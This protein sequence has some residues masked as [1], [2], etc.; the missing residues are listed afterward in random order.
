MGIY[1]DISRI[2]PGLEDIHISSGYGFHVLGY[3]HLCRYCT[4]AP[5]IFNLANIMHA[6]RYVTEQADDGQP[7]VLV[8]LT[9]PM[10]APG[11]PSP[12]QKF[13][14]HDVC[15]A[16]SSQAARLPPDQ[17]EDY[18]HFCR[19]VVFPGSDT[20]DVAGPPPLTP[21]SSSFSS[22]SCSHPPAPPT[23]SSPAPAPAP[24]T[25]PPPPRAL[26]LH[27]HLCCDA[28]LVL[29]LL[30][31]NLPPANSPPHSPTLILLCCCCC[32][33]SP[34]PAPALSPLPPLQPSCLLLLRR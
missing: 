30:P 29:L 7:L 28:V 17:I 10:Q 31:L 1:R 22:C 19:T 20:P 33:P 13:P 3:Q 24:H 12:S 14:V 23:A 5:L 6:Y 16:S 15:I 32:R 4:V 2:I 18:L 26:V 11:H 21:P 27:V 9:Q 34:L 8:L 25:P